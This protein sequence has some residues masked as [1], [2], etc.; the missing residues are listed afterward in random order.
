MVTE[1]FA[2]LIV[3]SQFSDNLRSSLS[4]N[5]F[6]NSQRDTLRECENLCEGHSAES[7]FSK[8]MVNR[9]LI[10][11][12]F[13]HSLEENCPLAA[14]NASHF[15]PCHFSSQINFEENMAKW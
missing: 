4:Y 1:I 14:I 12:I 15:L 7:K 13:K 5:F 9:G 8:N 2:S 11:N 3:T 6:S 10:F